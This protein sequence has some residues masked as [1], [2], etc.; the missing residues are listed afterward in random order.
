MKER[1]RFPLYDTWL[2]SAGTVDSGTVMD[3]FTVQKGSTGSGYADAKTEM[4]TNITTSGQMPY[5][6]FRAIGIRIYCYTITAAPVVAD[7]LNQL[8]HNSVVTFKKEDRTILQVP[9]HWIPSGIGMTGQSLAAGTPFTT[10]GLPVLSNL[11]RVL[12]ETYTTGDRI[13]LDITTKA[14]IT[15]AEDLHIEV[16]VEGVVDKKF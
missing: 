5:R 12:P 4:Q 7:D 13:Q 3:Y 2:Q 1:L 15:L 8:L 16:M 10:S 14:A 6:I 11:Y 9:T